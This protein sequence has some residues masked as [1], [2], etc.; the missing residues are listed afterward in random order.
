MSNI[1]PSMRHRPWLVLVELGDDEAAQGLDTRPA[2]INT[3]RHRGRSRR[4][5]WSRHESTQSPSL[6]GDQSMLTIGCELI[7]LEFYKADCEECNDQIMQYARI[8]ANI[9]SHIQIQRW[10][11]CVS[12]VGKWQ[13]RSVMVKH[14]IAE[15]HLQKQCVSPTTRRILRPP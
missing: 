2:N 9:Q 10:Q 12:V 4:L 3:E 14:T 6:S 1:P 7:T 5:T 15:S 13:W 11:Y 8:H